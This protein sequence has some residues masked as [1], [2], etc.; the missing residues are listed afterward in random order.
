[1]CA[2]DTKTVS[3]EHLSNVAGA[4][5]VKAG[6]LDTGIAHCGDGCQ[7][8]FEVLRALVPHAVELNRD[9]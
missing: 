1:M 6:E 7:S 3:R 5:I 8:P 4:A 2:G 9:L